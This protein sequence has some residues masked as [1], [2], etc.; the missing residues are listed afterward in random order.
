MWLIYLVI[1]VIGAAAL[2]ITAIVE[3][4][5]KIIEIISTHKKN[6]N[7]L[8]EI[9]KNISLHNI[10]NIRELELKLEWLKK[11]SFIERPSRKKIKHCQG[12]LSPYIIEAIQCYSKKIIKLE[13]LVNRQEITSADN[14]LKEI[15]CEKKRVPI[16]CTQYDQTLKSLEKN[17]IKLKS[18]QRDFDEGIQ[19]LQFILDEK[20]KNVANITLL[21]LN[22]LIEQNPSYR[23]FDKQLLAQLRNDLK[24]KH[25]IY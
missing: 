11:T 15:Q 21:K 8:K 9:T 25:L 1:L 7:E 2:A 19:H 4:I 17:I 3:L 13:D 23:H 12:L 18:I 20:I 10:G 24:I 22:I 16:Y 14:L 6:V 5:D